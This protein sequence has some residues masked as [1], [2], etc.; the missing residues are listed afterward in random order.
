M[1]NKIY[2]ILLVCACLL[3]GGVQSLWSQSAL[4]GQGIP[5]YLDPRTGAFHPA[6]PQD[7]AGDDENA[8]TPALTTYTGVLQTT[9][10]F[11]VKSKLPA[12]AITCELSAGTIDNGTPIYD[13]GSAVATVTA[14]QATCTP[15]FTYGWSLVNGSTDNVAFEYGIY[16]PQQPNGVSSRI[17]AGGNVT[18]PFSSL[19]TGT[20]T[21]TFT[22]TI[23][24]QF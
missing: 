24:T 15:K 17:S 13:I 2:T 6:Q 23:T 7:A 11:A 14:G 3:V 16:G 4:V 21:V 1:R 19:G 8:V 22:G 20:Y 12:G 18:V 5:G 10:K 9:L